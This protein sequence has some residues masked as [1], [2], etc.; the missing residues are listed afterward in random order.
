MGLDIYLSKKTFIGAM[1]D[2]CGISGIISIKKRGRKIPIKFRRVAYV[3]E[4]IYHGRKTHWLHEWLNHE[5]TD[6]MENSEEY[7]LD[8]DVINRLHQAC[9]E[10]LAH[11]NEP[12]FKKICKEKLHCELKPDFSDETLND[13]LDEVEELA[14][15]TDPSE[16]TDDAVFIV[17]ASW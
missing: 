8:K 17:S 1:F 12:D 11:R 13:F 7:E 9:I 2:S 6:G 5:L 16:K 4:D 14:E 10:V 15:A 3:I